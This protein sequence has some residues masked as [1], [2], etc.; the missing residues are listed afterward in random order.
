[1]KT[2]ITPTLAFVAIAATASAQGAARPLQLSGEYSALGLYRESDQ[3]VGLNGFGIRADY[4][5][6]RRV[7]IEGRA[8]WF[9]TDSLQE[10]EA[11]GG[12]TTQL[13]LGVRGRFLIW[14]RA[15]FYGVLL[16]ELLHF[17]NAIVDLSGPNV[18][19]GGATHFALDWGIGPRSRPAIGGEFISMRRGRCTRSA[20]S[21]SFDPNQMKTVRSRP[22]R[23]RREWS[24]SGR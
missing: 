19:S 9:P 10:V 24:M 3:E 23:L 14:N 4:R 5:L 6:T 15:S 13:A 1:V 2:H 17:S 21:N 18:V 22:D 11:Q 7:D 12:K 8:L 16:P 20:K